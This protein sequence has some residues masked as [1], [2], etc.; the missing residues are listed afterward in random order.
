[1]IY[2][3]IEQ[4]H[5]NGNHSPRIAN[6]EQGQKLSQGVV[7]GQWTTTRTEG[8]W[9]WSLR[10]LNKCTIVKPKYLCD[11]NIIDADPKFKTDLY[12]KDL[13][14]GYGAIAKYINSKCIVADLR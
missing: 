14:E 7:C 9:E 6:S 8:P 10:H 11:D 2:R 3:W 1:M 13:K 4:S 12:A 5:S